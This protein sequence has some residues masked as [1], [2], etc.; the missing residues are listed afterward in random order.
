MAA[1][2]PIIGGCWLANP[3]SFYAQKSK[4]VAKRKREEK[5]ERT[6]DMEA[7][8]LRQEMKRRGHIAVPKHGEGPEQVRWA[9]MISCC[10]AT[11]RPCPTHQ[12]YI[13]SATKCNVEPIAGQLSAALRH[14]TYVRRHC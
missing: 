7:R 14:R 6:V 9:H 11:C 10:R 5:A 4:S 3:V 8:H 13:G 12:A 1:R 2:D